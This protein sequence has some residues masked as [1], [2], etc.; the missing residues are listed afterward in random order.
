M[1]RNLQ[2]ASTS[3]AE[4][5]VTVGAPIV[6]RDGSRVRVRQLHRS[7]EELLLGG[8]ERL[9]PESRYQRFLMPMP[10]LTARV[11]RY[12]TDI[13]HHDHEAIIALDEAGGEGVGVGRYVRD[14]ERLDVAEVA[15]TVSDDWQGRGL[16]TVLLDL[17]SARARD[18]GV[19]TLKA[20]ILAT[21]EEMMA[22]LTHLG[23]ARIVGREV[24]RVEIEVTTPSAGVAP[25]LRRLCPIAARD[26]S[27]L[28]SARPGRGAAIRARGRTRSA[29]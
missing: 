17:I 29:A 19:T 15:V 10:A 9:S 20:L 25:A 18:E 22:L 8:F 3:C 24:G 7:D 2:M 23:P 13:D 26:D 4:E 6:L 1:A 14:P 16:G 11:V 28:P 21:N 5:L 27:A 12:L